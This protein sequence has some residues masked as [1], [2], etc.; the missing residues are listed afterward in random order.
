[1]LSKAASC[2]PHVPEMQDQQA[3]LTALERHP[4][5][6]PL[7][8]M[9]LLLPNPPLLPPLPLLLPVQLF[10]LKLLHWLVHALQLPRLVVADA[11]ADET[12]DEHACRLQP[13]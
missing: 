6:E 4:A 10:R 3:V 2:E 13:L 7:L 12:C 1:M 11:H 5:P 8:P 9:P